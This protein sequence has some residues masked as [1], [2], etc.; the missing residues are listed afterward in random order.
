M[1]GISGIFNILN[2][3]ISQLNSKL[4]TLN[5]L[6]SHRGP[7]NSGIWKSSNSSVGL[8]HTRLSIIDLN[9]RANQPMISDKNNIISFNGE[10]YNFKSLK[11]R[12][13]CY[14]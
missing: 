2:Q 4:D 1:C 3:P 8:A 7:D 6:L 9:D 12:T 5:N 10:I 13:I 14:R 11:K